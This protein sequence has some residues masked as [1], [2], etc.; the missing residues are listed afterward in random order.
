M[1]T[2]NQNRT[3]LSIWGRRLILTLGATLIGAMVA[4]SAAIALVVSIVVSTLCIIFLWPPIRGVPGYVWGPLVG[5]GL[6]V[7]LPHLP[8]V[9]LNL[10]ALQLSW[11]ELEHELWVHLDVPI[12]ILSLSY[13]S[14]SLD[15][16]GFFNWSSLRIMRLGR[17]EGRM[18]LLYLFAGVSTITFLTSNDI[19]ILAMSPILIHLGRNARLENLTPFLMAQF[20]AA[21]TASMGLYIGNP[22]NIVIGNTVGLGFADYAQRMF[23]PTVI[24]AIS[25]FVLVFFIFTIGSRKNRIPD[26]YSIPAEALDARWT[27][28]MTIKASVF[29]LCLLALGVFGNPWSAE[30]LLGVSDPEII[31]SSV[32]KLIVGIS[33]L[34]ATLALGLDSVR[35]LFDDANTVA[36]RFTRRAKRIPFEIVPFFLSFCTILKGIESSGLTRKLIDHLVGMFH[37]GPI[38]GGLASGFYVVATVNIMNNIPSTILFEKLWLGD[39]N[40]P[41]PFAGLEHRLSDLH[42]VYSDIFIDCS[43]FASNFGANLTFI[44][45]LAGLMWFRIIRDLSREHPDAGR[46]PSAA[47][48]LGYGIIIVP[49][50]TAITCFFI[51]WLRV[52]VS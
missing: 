31:R 6:M 17:G 45:A 2:Q 26:K 4:P 12:L 16:S 8:V 36:S 24:A 11:A 3:A 39:S 15:S 34:F 25:A 46:V 32:S 40:G 1:Q 22:T 50:V 47:D 18:L 7:G 43:L 21:N 48:F 35:D 10:T 37:N 28:D 30:R 9:G 13:L 29:G 19:V 23:A 5:A 27:R 33:V 41:V 51:S 20:I 42:P 14:V 44:G 52:I 49:I 38:I